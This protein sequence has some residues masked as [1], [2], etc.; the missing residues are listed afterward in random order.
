M[1][2]ISVLN[3][4]YKYLYFNEVHY[5]SNMKCF[6]SEIKVNKAFE[7]I[8]NSTLIFQLQTIKNNLSLC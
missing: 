3:L 5:R 6:Y 1:Y 2:L 8:D 7:P 4:D